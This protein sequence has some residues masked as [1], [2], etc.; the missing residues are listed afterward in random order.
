ML[1][2]DA[3]DR[4]VLDNG[5]VLDL[6]VRD[7]EFLGIGEVS[8]HG[9][10]IRNGKRPWFVSLRSPDGVSFS[11]YQ[12]VAVE[13]SASLG[14]AVHLEPRTL[15]GGEMDWMVHEA[16]S[17][18]NT[19]DWTSA[20]KKT[21]GTRI[22]LEIAPAERIMGGLEYVGFSYRFHYASDTVALYKILDRGTW[23]VGGS[24]LENEFWMRNCFTP[25]VARFEEIEQHY[26]TEWYLPS[27]ANPNIFQFLPLQTELQGFTYTA[28]PEGTL[29]TW[30]TDVSHIRSLFE[31]KA[32]VDEIEHWHEHCADLGLEWST[33]PVEVLLGP[34]TIDG[35]SR[36]NNYEAVRSYV[37]KHLHDRA[38][39][40]EDRVAP[41]G[42]IEEWGPPDFDRYMIGLEKLL[43]AGAEIIFIPNQFQ[44]N[45]NVWGISNM[46]C[47][48][49]YKLVDESAAERLRRFGA[50]IAE[51]GAELEMWGN[52]SISTATI[53]FASRNGNEARIAFLPV[54]GS[55]MET[56]DRASDPFVRTPSGAIEADHYTPVFAV[57]NLRD[58]VIRDYWMVAW[59][60]AVDS[61]GLG[62]I[63]LDSSFNLT[64]DKF[65]YL[66]NA[67][68][69]LVG[70]TADQAQLLGLE[71][72]SRQPQAVIQSMY[73]VHLEIVAEMQ[74]LGI[75]YCNEDLGVF[76]RHRHGPGVASR[77]TCLML[78]PECICNFDVPSLKDCG[79][80]LD[81]V[82]FRG[83]AYRMMW[84]IAWDIARDVLSFHTYGVRGDFDIPS[85][86]QL[87]VYKAF[88]KLNAHMRER[89]I[90][91]HEQGVIYRSESTMV[92]WAFEEM[93]FALDGPNTITD[94]LSSTSWT[95]DVIIAKRR[96][97][98]LIDASD[99]AAI[100]HESH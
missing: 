65:H 89:T 5:T 97:A 53:M 77:L 78:W 45:M 73:R 14:V 44:N 36:A 61:F 54:E 25:A 71:R 82:F 88:G 16:R 98:Y 63:F 22:I 62:A 10:S 60:N 58:P 2:Y 55:I 94:V 92:L 4:I 76:G 26:S 15:P 47:T 99:G 84:S 21:S 83:L 68:A 19:S 24:S 59:K 57:L 28:S 43:D 51:R 38:G 20:P 6:V 49:D 18:Y 30:A 56:I 67:S 90:L 72:P 95:S 66:Q 46:C 85:E 11:D 34:G 1:V 23:E 79:A 91:P 27:A 29:V 80:D 39:L 31:K 13:Q 33:S 93:E 42:M 8:V 70:A 96:C 86:W 50:R 7:G 75:R 40:E 48:V 17:R 37:S 12:V 35:V 32:G 52:T 64:S 9:V 69:G 87:S 100:C 74:K 81:D 3:L 41:Y